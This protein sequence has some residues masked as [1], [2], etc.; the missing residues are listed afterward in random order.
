MSD[1]ELQQVLRVTRTQY[2]PRLFATRSTRARS[3][4][5]KDRLS[6][7][8]KCSSL[9]ADNLMNFSTFVCMVSDR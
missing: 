6:N 7:L 2:V 5:H 8:T 3:P 9:Q 1:T 4:V